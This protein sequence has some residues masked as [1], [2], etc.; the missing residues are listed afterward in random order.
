MSYIYFRIRPLQSLFSRLLLPRARRL[1]T[2]SHALS[3][4]NTIILHYITT[5][6]A[7]LFTVPEDY[8]RIRQAPT[9]RSR[10]KRERLHDHLYKARV[11]VEAGVIFQYLADY[12]T[13]ILP[14]RKISCKQPVCNY[15]C[16]IPTSN[17]T[18]GSSLVGLCLGLPASYPFSPNVWLNTMDFRIYHEKGMFSGEV[19]FISI[20]GRSRIGRVSEGATSK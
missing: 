12:A 13:H 9:S 3:F 15:P 7:K 17:F 4:F 1:P 11:P 18:W 8:E 2:I 6:N 10:N 20:V 16:P 19:V 5:S 14:F